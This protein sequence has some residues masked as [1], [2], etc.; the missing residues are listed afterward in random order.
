MAEAK[1]NL[2]N[3]LGSLVQT[4]ASPLSIPV[5]QGADYSNYTLT[6]LSFDGSRESEPVAVPD[7][8][9]PEPTTTT[10]T[11]KAPEPTTPPTTT[12]TTTKAP[13]A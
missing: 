12:T 13:E 8:T 1:F 2:Y 4:G 9:I 10:T 6:H 3:G 11:T 7:F 5:T